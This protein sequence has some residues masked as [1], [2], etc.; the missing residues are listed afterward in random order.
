MKKL[1]AGIFT[2][3]LGLVAA[4][5]NAAVTTKNYVDALV[6]TKQDKLEAGTGID[7]TQLAQKIVAIDST[8]VAS[9]TDLSNLKTTV[10]G[11]T[12]SITN[13]TNNKQNNLTAGNDISIDGDTIATKYKQGTNIKFETDTDGK[14]KISTD[15]IATTEGMKEL[16]DTVAGHTQSITQIT[17]DLEG[18]QDTL[19]STNV[20]TDGNG[21]YVTGVSANNGTVTV[22]TGNLPPASA[23][24][25]GVVRLKSA[26]EG[27]NDAVTGQGVADA[28]Q[29]AVSGITS[30]LEGKQNTLTD[31][32]FT[33]GNGVIV[34]VKDGHVTITG[35][36]A[37][38]Q[39]AGVVTLGAGVSDSEE[40]VVTGKQVAG[41]IKKAV[42]DINSELE[43]KLSSED[44]D[45]MY[46]PLSDGDGL[47]VGTADGDW[48]VLQAGANITI[49]KTTGTIGTTGLATSTELEGVKNTVDGLGT[50]YKTIESYNTDTTVTDGTYIKADKD[51]KGNLTALDVQLK[52]A[53]DAATS[54]AETA[55]AAIPRPDDDTCDTTEGC[56]LKFQGGAYTWEPLVDATQRAESLL[57]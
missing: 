2:V 28:I 11:H 54:A 48:K 45:G 29:N 34:S 52:T 13:L 44:A 6:D 10:E 7:A 42:D 37:T 15:G 26:T 57:P 21:A 5:A 49:D 35:D 25:L 30:D 14:I 55:T 43:D 22:T 31:A 9:A 27:N 4:N 3:M 46:Q 56:V 33:D 32:D 36:D 19:G 18:K 53:T 20:T 50:T 51:V 40:G 12:T 16:Q 8:A 23:T 1:T 47:N 41:A 39:K 38:T 24:D 17:S